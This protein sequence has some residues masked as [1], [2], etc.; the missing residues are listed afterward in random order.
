[1][2]KRMIVDGMLE[3]GVFPNKAEA[4]AAYDAVL[5]SL[6][7]ALRE[8]QDVELR[9]FGSFRVV[10]RKARTGRNPRTGEP[11]AIPARRAV[12]FR[13]G[14]QMREAQRQ[15]PEWLGLKTY[16]LLL[17]SQVREARAFLKRKQ[18]K[19]KAERYAREAAER[20]T[21]LTDEAS[22]RLKDYSRAGKPAWEELRQGLERAYGELKTAFLKARDKF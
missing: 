17:E 5:E 2:S 6:A 1:M 21:R 13:A 12:I 19:A 10:E 15:G 22:A 7:G 16:S 3:S 4:E 11:V 8:G 20:L 9:P 14:A 18:V